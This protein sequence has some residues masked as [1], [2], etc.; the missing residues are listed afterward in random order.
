M[1]LPPTF[2]SLSTLR[3]KWHLA[4]IGAVCSMVS[5]AMSLNLVEQTVRSTREQLH[6]ARNGQLPGPWSCLPR[7]AFELRGKLK[8]NFVTPPP[9]TQTLIS[10]FLELLHNRVNTL[11]T[12]HTKLWVISIC[13]AT[14]NTLCNLRHLVDYGVSSCQLGQT[15]LSVP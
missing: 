6:V 5:L 12:V 13:E 11:N 7:N 15:P 3:E 10:V 14:Q 9:T 1:F 8:S 4:T 2:S